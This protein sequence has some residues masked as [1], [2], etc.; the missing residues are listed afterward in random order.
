MPTGLAAG[1]TI[2]V[3][4]WGAGSGGSGGNTSN[5]AGGAGGAYATNTYTLSSND[6]ANGVSY[7]LQAGSS[8]TGSASSS[9]G[10]NTSWSTNNLNLNPSTAVST[11]VLGTIGSGGAVP[12]GWGFETVPSGISVEVVR[13]GI[14]TDGYQTVDLR[15]S[16]TSAAGGDLHT[17]L[18]C[19]G[20]FPATYTPVTAGSAYTHS[21]YVAVV[22]GSL[23]SQT[24]QQFF[25]YFT[26]AGGYISTS[27]GST[28]TPTGTLT[29][30]TSANITAAATAAY[31]NIQCVSTIAAGGTID[32]T[33]RIGAAQVEIGTTASFFKTTPG[34][35]LAKGGNG[36]SGTTG[37]IGGAAA[38]CIP[39]TGAFSGGNG[40]TRT[41]GGGG[42]GSAGKDGA[43]ASATTG[44]GG[45]GDNGSGGAANTDTVEGGGGGTASTSGHVGG[46][47]GGGGG[48]NTST[49]T[50]GAGGR[51]QIRLTYTA[52][53]NVYWDILVPADTSGAPRWDFLVRSETLRTINNDGLIQSE[54]LALAPV[55]QSPA[56]EFKG[57]S[58]ADSA[59]PF[60]SYGQFRL[61]GI[62][63]YSS[64]ASFSIDDSFPLTSLIFERL[65]L[66]LVSE[67]LLVSQQD[68]GVPASTSGQITKDDA[69]PVERSGLWREDISTSAEVLQSSYAETKYSAEVLSYSL[70]DRIVPDEVY[71]QVRLD[72]NTPIEKLASGRADANFATEISTKA[73]TD[74]PVLSEGLGLLRTD[75]PIAANWLGTSN[76]S[77]DTQ[78]TLEWTLGISTNV[79]SPFDFTS[80]TRSDRVITTEQ[81]AGGRSDSTAY[82][83]SS[84]GVRND[85]SPSSENLTIARSDSA[86]PGSWLSHVF[87][88]WRVP[89]EWSGTASVVVSYDSPTNLEWLSGLASNSSI[90]LAFSGA[91]R[92]DT[93]GYSELLGVVRSN[94]PAHQEQLVTA[95]SD[96]PI[97]TDRL[98]YSLRDLIVPTEWS[99]TPTIGVSYDSQIFLEVTAGLT[100]DGVTSIDRSILGRADWQT[101]SERLWATYATGVVPS[102]A[103]ISSSVPIVGLMETVANVFESSSLNTEVLGTSVSVHYDTAAPIEWL[104]TATFSAASQIE[105]A[106]SVYEDHQV[107]TDWAAP[108]IVPPTSNTYVWAEADRV[109]IRR[110][111]GYPPYGTGAVVFPEPW[112]FRYYLAL[113]ARLSNMTASEADAIKLYLTDLRTLETALPAASANLDTNRAAVWV[114]NKN[115]LSDRAALY[116]TWRLELCGTVGI[117]PGPYLR[118]DNPIG[119]G[120]GKERKKPKRPSLPSTTRKTGRRR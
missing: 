88:G 66:S 41:Q 89:A 54:R 49:G 26:S 27:S 43:G 6:I 1:S 47:P 114:H 57:N 36:T 18:T 46:A 8:G 31:V 97:P 86:V 30:V 64:S 44:T 12:A 75:W 76:I 96:S 116:Q 99:G 62:V 72:W 69:S 82:F 74:G 110:Y 101:G 113:E 108:S 95:S 81:L 52:G 34:Y 83:S 42:G 94:A 23:G 85:N 16:G 102:E 2:T 24:F 103:L 100:A 32:F 98:A 21:F 120:S 115:E 48:A 37:G 77:Y 117:P 109:D 38:S 29:R 104:Q 19:E 55:D 3:E 22:S 68:G 78:N 106:L 45:T 107:S 59:V 40:A 119:P 5:R 70:S 91:A 63:P 53:T 28:F 20:A 13:A 73:S 14:D 92:S 17:Y 79:P 112:V 10:P 7:L 84:S 71:A 118:I 9:A 33:L 58:L 4:L 11:A 15:Y 50:G 93:L 111:C 61:D 51:G 56:L 65:D 90:S 60:V 67:R 87:D 35:T 105:F 39:T 25:D 80:A